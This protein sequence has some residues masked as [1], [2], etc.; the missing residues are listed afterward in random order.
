MGYEPFTWGIETLDKLLRTA[1]TPGSSI[2]LAGNPGTGKTTLAATICY[3]NASMGK[4]CLYI[5][6]HEEKKR[7]INQMKKFGMDFESLERQNL[8]KFLRLPLMS[9]EGTVTDIVASISEYAEKQEAKLVVIDS[10]TPLGK[11]VN[12]DIKARTL[13]QNFFYNLAKAI[14]GI[15]VLIAEVPL[16]QETVALGD[17]EFVADTAIILK[18]RIAKGGTVI[19]TLEIRKARG[20]PLTLAEIPFSIVDYRGIVVHI[21]PLINELKP[22]RMDI[23]I[24]L[25]CETLNEIVDHLHPGH[26][27]YIVVPPDARSYDYLMLLL[28]ATI[29][30]NNLRTLIVSYYWSS[31]EYLTILRNLDKDLTSRYANP[32]NNA[33]EKLLQLITIESLNPAAVSLEELYSR[34]LTKIKE[35]EPQ[36]V[37]FDR[38]DIVA[39]IHGIQDFEKYFAYLRN[40]LLYLRQLNILTTRISALVDSYVYHREASIADAVFRIE[41]RIENAVLKPY[42]YVWRC[43]RRPRIIDPD[44]LNRCIMEAK[45]HFRG[46]EHGK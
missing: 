2:L 12:G 44:A 34:E 30:A 20:A 23:R 7:F 3:R 38:V 1:L 46:V 24:K 21:P 31:E 27:V 14:N 41:Y 11:A 29:L 9:D 37:I 42:L 13:L 40:E 17:I 36:L 22:P 43:G 45:R 10:F 33:I 26:H 35:R 25:P 39:S 4:P 5:T 6:F 32:S 18:H 16:G 15:V 8:F 19:R 28:A